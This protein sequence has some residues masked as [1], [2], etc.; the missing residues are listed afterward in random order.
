VN[1]IL[2][3][4]EVPVLYVLIHALIMEFVTYREIVSAMVIGVELHVL[5]VRPIGLV[6]IVLCVI[7]IV[8]MVSVLIL[9]PA[10]VILTHGTH[11]LEIFVN[12][13]HSVSHR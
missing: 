8:E 13:Q 9:E 10:S 5:F 6:Q 2:N 7:C 4:M 11:I 1:V 3:G 12:I